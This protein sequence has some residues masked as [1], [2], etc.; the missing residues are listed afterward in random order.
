MN[1]LKRK[2]KKVQINIT[3]LNFAM[4]STQHLFKA[5]VP[6][7]NAILQMDF[8]SCQSVSPFTVASRSTKTPS[9]QKMTAYKCSKFCSFSVRIH[10]FPSLVTSADDFNSHSNVNTI[11]HYHIIHKQIFF[12]CTCC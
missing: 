8:C 5:F 2:K 11:I 1:A 12:Y 4:E 3:I 10:F 9:V 6:I 7:T